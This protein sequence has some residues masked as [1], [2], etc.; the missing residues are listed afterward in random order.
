MPNFMQRSI[1]F[2]QP[3]YYYYHSVL[4]KIFDGDARRVAS[5]KYLDL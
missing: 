3:N 5:L 1:K 2:A 4:L